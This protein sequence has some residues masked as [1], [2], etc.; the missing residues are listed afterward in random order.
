MLLVLGELS[1]L[2]WLVYVIVEILGAVVGAFIAAAADPTA[3]SFKA[4][5]LD[6]ELGVGCV[7]NPKFQLTFLC[8]IFI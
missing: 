6:N 5:A 7:P 1:S 2:K 8:P 3:P 4:W